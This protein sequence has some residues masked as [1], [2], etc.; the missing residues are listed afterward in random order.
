MSRGDQPESKGAQELA[1]SVSGVVEAG[2]ELV[3][4]N[5]P[6]NWGCNNKR[7]I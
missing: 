4:E 1:L 3:F 2:R 7:N 6:E 5:W